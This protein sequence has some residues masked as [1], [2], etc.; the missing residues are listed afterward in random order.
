MVDLLAQYGVV[1]VFAWV[2][3]VEAAMPTPPGPMLLGA[4]ALSGSGQ[5]NLTLALGAAIA[6][7]LGADVLWYSLGRSQGTRLLETLCRFSMNP[8]SVVRDV[9][10]RFVAH[11]VRFVVLAKFLPGVNPIA[12]RLAGAVPLRMRRFLLS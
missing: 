3:A 8:D 2:F 7:A 10:E 6:A 1:L 11:G 5:M 4:G 12:A 9:K